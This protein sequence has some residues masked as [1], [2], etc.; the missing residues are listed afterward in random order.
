MRFRYVTLNS[1]QEQ[2]SGEI[3]AADER[4][5]ARQVY[6]MGTIPV[7]LEPLGSMTS[8]GGAALGLRRQPPAAKRSRDEHGSSFRLSWRGSGIS[9]AWCGLLFRQIGVLLQAGRPVHEALQVLARAGE[10]GARR[11]LLED[12]AARVQQGSTLAQALAAHPDV[13]AHNVV[14]LV[15][16]GEEGGTLESVLLSLAA[17]LEKDA[18][19]R[20][21]LKT[22][23]IYPA[24]LG[25]AVLLAMTFMTVFI[26]PVV[27]GMLSSL[28]A[29]L[30]LPT[31]LLLGFSDILE[32]HGA[33]LLLGLVLAAAAGVGCYATRQGR[34]RLDRMLLHLP[35]L[36]SMRLYG[37]WGLVLRTAGLLTG[38]GMP[39]DQAMKLVPDLPANRCLQVCLRD[40]AE[41]M[42]A[43]QPLGRLLARCGL[44]PP[45]LLELVTSGLE[46]GNME[47]MLQQAADI[48]EART[49]R[50]AERMQ[51]LAEPV[52][53]IVLGGLVAFFVM[54]VL[55][56]LLSL[57]D[58][59][60]Y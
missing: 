4:S 42:S 24:I 47:Q 23:L 12:L 21:R 9:P 36:G 52:C 25:T 32:H 39:L 54:A 59:V 14:M 56:P 49:E 50:Y 1:H 7:K 45:L 55:L 19:A 11:R 28:Q 41:K 35:V 34:L 22:S 43:G 57:M 20:E 15:H 31:R 6:D 8:G 10:R 53:I 2:F 17:C 46:S 44:F 13:F 48:C 29:E 37:E 16:S 18:A 33:Q 60:S 40:V 38:N 26:L 58:S 5:A 3:E 30:P 51:T 27:A